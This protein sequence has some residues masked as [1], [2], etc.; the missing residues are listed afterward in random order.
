[1][2]RLGFI[3]TL[4]AVALISQPALC[5]AGEIAA[6]TSKRESE[7][8]AVARRTTKAA[9]L[10]SQPMP[11]GQNTCLSYAYDKNGNRTSMTTDSVAT[12]SAVWGASAYPCFLWR[13]P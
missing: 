3:G 1:M 12:N 10:T 4:L 6:G 11:S 7:A 2:I 5:F 13:A 8:G 9:V